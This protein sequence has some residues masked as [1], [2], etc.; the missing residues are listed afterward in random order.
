MWKATPSAAFLGDIG[1]PPSTYLSLRPG[2]AI[3]IGVARIAG[4][5]AVDRIDI[6]RC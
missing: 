3:D 5:D 1:D 4:D 2:R 6:I